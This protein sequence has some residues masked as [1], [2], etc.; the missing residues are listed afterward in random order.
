MKGIEVL[1]TSFTHLPLEPAVTLALIGGDGPASAEHRR[2][3]DLARELGIADRVRFLGTVPHHAM[4]R[5]YR[6]AD[7]VVVASRYESFGLVILE[8]MASGTPVASTPVGI[9][10]D[11][12]QPGVNG[13]PGAG[14]RSAAPC[15]SRHPDT[16]AGPSAGSDENQGDRHEIRVAAPGIHA[17]GCLL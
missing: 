5:H 7:A 13:Y 3:V 1:L 4:P 10:P 11:L 12:I 6:E 9:A 15:G 8:S 14:R 2:I 16:V 17:V